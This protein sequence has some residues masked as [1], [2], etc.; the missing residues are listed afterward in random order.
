MR[1][2]RFSVIEV[3]SVGQAPS[4]VLG[5]QLPRPEPGIIFGTC[6]QPA[7]YGIL[8]HVLDL[9]TQTLAGTQNV[10]EGFAQPQWPPAT[11]RAVD[12]VRGR[13]LQPLHDERQVP[14]IV[15]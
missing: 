2:S 13:S 3:Q 7:P 6:N 5:F 12:Q 10:V 14:I 8:S 15:R 9:L 1:L 4:P 11:R